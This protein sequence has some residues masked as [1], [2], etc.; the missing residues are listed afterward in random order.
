M[1]KMKLL[2]IGLPKNYIE[3]NRFKS[4]GFSDK[5]LSQLTKTSRNSG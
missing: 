5:K 4:I 3:F 1:L 2:K